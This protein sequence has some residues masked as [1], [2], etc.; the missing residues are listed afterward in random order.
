LGSKIVII[1]GAEDFMKQ[2]LYRMEYLFLFFIFFSYLSFAG[3]LKKK[4]EAVTSIEKHKAEL[5]TLSDQI[6]AFA[7]T[8]LRETK[9]SKLLADYAEQQG[10][11]VERG[12]AGMPTAFVATYGEGKPIIGILG[13]FDALPGISQ[14]A[15]P[16]K[17]PYEAGA[18][19]HGCGHNLFGAGSLGAAVAI[20]E[21]IAAGKLKG[22]IRFYGTPAEES[23]GGKIYMARDGLFNDLDVCLAWHPDEKTKADVQSSQ[24]LVD[25]IVEFHGKA[26]HAAFDPW[27]GRSAVDGLELFTH[28]LNM[29]REHVKPS[30]RIHYAIQKGGDV[31]NVI[32]EYAKIWCWVR[33]S[34]RTGVEE[35]L[36]RVREIAKGA[37]MMAGVESKLT[38]QTGDYEML[39]NM[40]GAK[41]LQANLTWLGP[42]QYTEEEQTFARA[43][44]R[45]TGV[46][47]KGL[48][49]AIQPLEEPKPDPPGGSTDV[50]DVSWIVPTLHVSVTTAAEGAPWHAWPVVAC[51]GMSIGHKGMLHAAKILAATMVDLFE[52]AKTREAIQAEFK[53]KTKGH[54]Y[55]PYIPDGPPPVPAN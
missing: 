6:W 37:A 45:E 47:E 28:G 51:G 10:F 14:K 34:K 35:V 22:T 48:N 3:D 18:A 20:K 36:A 43:I 32:P 17:D 13:E 8:A 55:K 15:S 29:L 4:S 52:D 46:E 31:P 9:S 41:L 16:V 39:V 40:A 44:Q 11:K 42:I 53:E 25:F 19:G 38:V 23:V 27:N 30:V 24:A 5:I 54:I 26:A 12:V 1:F 49:G 50:A 2:R 7:E 21:L 33:D